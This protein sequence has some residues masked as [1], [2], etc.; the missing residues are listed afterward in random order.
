MNA[1]VTPESSLAR[2]RS[3]VLDAAGIADHDLERALA[4]LMRG[5]VDN[6]DLYFQVSRQESWT[7]EDGIVK[8][9]AHSIEQGVGVRAMSGEKTGFAYSD[10]LVVPALLQ[11]LVEFPRFS[12]P[13]VTLIVDPAG[14]LHVPLSVSVWPVATVSPRLLM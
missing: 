2:V 3:Q 11:A 8:E 10:E 5:T 14:L 4:A 7:L 13:P 6:A 12:V 9:G 1:V